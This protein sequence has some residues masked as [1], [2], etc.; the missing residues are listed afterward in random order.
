MAGYLELLTAAIR[1]LLASRR[2]L[3]LENLALRHQL[4]MCGRRSRVRAGDRLLWGMLLR[5][6]TGWRSALVVLHPGTVVRWHRQG[7][8]TYWKW[9]SR[10]RRG[11]RPR[12]DI[13]AREL[14]IRIAR[15]NP[16]WGAVRIRG[17]LLS[18]GHDVSAASVRRYRRQALRLP[19]SQRWHAFLENHR[20]ELWA[21]D[22]FTVPTVL[23]RTL[24]VFVVVSHDRGAS[25]TSMSPRIRRLHGSG[26]R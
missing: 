16:R 5:R 7:W 19:P 14:I 24:Y 26:S 22:F 13:E 21:A 2:D 17:E 25:N 12:I 18:L 6:W 11:G 23:F 4:A 1:G 9:K 8:R 3:V 15:E 10:P 20:R